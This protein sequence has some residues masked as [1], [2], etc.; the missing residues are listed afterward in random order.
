[1]DEDSGI[2]KRIYNGNCRR[3]CRYVH[4][5]IF[6]LFA[7]LLVEF[8]RTGIEINHIAWFRRPKRCIYPGFTGTRTTS[9]TSAD[10]AFTD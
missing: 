1:M 8:S 3:I 2:L 7:V 4:R 5:P 9:G 6:M 10:A